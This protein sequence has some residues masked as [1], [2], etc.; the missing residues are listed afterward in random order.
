MFCY[1]LLVFRPCLGGVLVMFSRVVSRLRFAGVFPV[2][3]S[4]CIGHVS[5]FS[6]S[7]LGGVLLVVFW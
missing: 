5:V 6:R 3:F 1:V 4:W 7:C 2:M